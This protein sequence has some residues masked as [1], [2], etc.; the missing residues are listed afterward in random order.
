MVATLL[1]VDDDPSFRSL[2][3]AALKPR[4]YEVQG[5]GNIR[6]ADEAM[7]KHI[8]TVVVLDLGLPD[9]D[10]ASWLQRQ[11]AAG[12]KG[13]VVVV[14]AAWQS[15]GAFTRLQSSLGVAWVAHKPLVPKA[16]A[17]QLVHLAPPTSPLTNPTTDAETE[18]ALT[19]LRA[20]Y[21]ATLPA[22]IE[23][24]RTLVTAYYADPASAVDRRRLENLSHRL[25]G[26]A[27]SYGFVDVS[28]AAARIQNALG[29]QDLPQPALA[30][31]IH[32]ALMEA[33]AAVTAGL[34]PTI[35]LP[36]RSPAHR[37]TVLLV[38][39]DGQ[40]RRVIREAGRRILVET[41]AVKDW[42]AAVAHLANGTVNAVLFD[43]AFAANAS[44]LRSVTPSGAQGEPTLG[45]VGDE[46]STSERVEAVGMGARVFLG[47]RADSAACQEAL[48]RLLIRAEEKS[49]ILLAEDD[50][51]FA[52]FV[53]VVLEK[54]GMEV[55]LVS[56]VDALIPALERVQ[57]DLL[58]LDQIL[59]GAMGV[60][61]CR[62]VRLSG[63]WLSLPIVLITQVQQR[64]TRLAAYLGG[65]DDFIQKPVQADELLVRVQAR[66]RRARELHEQT[67]RDPLTGLLN[68]RM[69]TEQANIRVSEAR[70]HGRPLSLAL[71]DIDHFKLV[72]DRFGHAVGDMVL[73]ALGRLLS[74]RF[75]AEDLRGRWGGEELV[76]AFPGQV[77]G[78]VLQTTDHLRQE[79]SAIRFQGPDRVPFHVT[80]TAGVVQL[81]PDGT[82]LGALIGAADRYLYQ[83]KAN[84]RNRVLART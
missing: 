76:I 44:L 25:A 20:E 57:P 22:Q 1:I 72:N 71:L 5:A 74:T 58:M 30:T 62:A 56:T 32:L 43:M 38:G 80:F 31:E 41:V 36:P 52:A 23:E 70:R 75:R 9:G 63:R 53:R 18:D 3:A 67:D 50:P 81:G 42:A 35:G 61:L 10:G 79:F 27:G 14:S 8:V 77:L 17:E 60:E 6:E 4:G 83:A 2:L 78:D 51:H 26:T 73:S 16:L 84:G 55:H 68:R 47:R 40:T 33:E 21:A 12:W 34:R 65:V 49:R 45:V 46:T 69:F 39:V 48:G 7:R 15:E 82:D 28:R 64:S 66:L 54:S 19:A 29:G 59:I 13:V 37:S 24:L 11:R